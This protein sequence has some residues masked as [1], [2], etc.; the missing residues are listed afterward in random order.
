MEM[1]VEQQVT[2]KEDSSLEDSEM[3]TLPEKEKKISLE[4]KEDKKEEFTFGKKKSE[5]LDL[6]Y[7]L[8]APRE[9]KKQGR[10]DRLPTF[11][12]TGQDVSSNVQIQEMGF[13]T[14]LNLISDEKDRREFL[15]WAKAEAHKQGRGE[16]TEKI[17]KKEKLALDKEKILEKGGGKVQKVKV[18][19]NVEK[20][21]TRLSLSR[22][23]AAHDKS[24]RVEKR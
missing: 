6:C 9:A 17:S 10:L 13:L 2:K 5:P 18:Q 3:K 21:P 12:E 1:S 14:M 15:M 4:T 11:Q 24:H 23:S 8:H 7:R 20:T 19:R 16:K 22:R